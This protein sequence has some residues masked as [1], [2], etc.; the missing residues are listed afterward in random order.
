M[1]SFIQAIATIVANASPEDRAM[2]ATAMLDFKNRYWRSYS[3]M[4]TSGHAIAK[5]W[6]AVDEVLLAPASERG[7]Q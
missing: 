1:K 3:A 4:L 2:L 5:L 7:T 6:N